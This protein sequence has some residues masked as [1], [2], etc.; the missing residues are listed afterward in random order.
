MVRRR[1]SASLATGI[2]VAAALAG[3]GAPPD[4]FD[5]RIARLRSPEILE[6]DAAEADLAT[7]DAATL[8]RLAEALLAE[9]DPDAR[10]RIEAVFRSLLGPI[11]EQWTSRQVAVARSQVELATI[12]RRAAEGTIPEADQARAQVLRERIRSDSEAIRTTID[13]LRALG[14]AAYPLLFPLS[15]YRPVEARPASAAL[16]QEAIAS[17][18]ADPD[19]GDRFERVRYFL[20]HVWRMAAREGEAAERAARLLSRHLEGTFDDAFG[21]ERSQRIRA[22]AV[23]EL[24]LLDEEAI[25]F[26]RT[27]VPSIEDGVGHDARRLLALL[28]R[29]I[30]ASL[31]E[32]T[33][34][35]LV[36]FEGRS[37]I[38][39]RSA[40]YEME[41]LGREDAIPALRRILRTDPSLSVQFAAA[42]SLARLRDGD[43]IRYLEE[44]GPEELSNLPAVSRQV[45]LIE[46]I[47]LR[48]AGDLEGS[49][50]KLRA[51]LEESPGDFRANYEM[52]FT[53]LLARR[54][55]EAIQHFRRALEVDP[56]DVLSLYNLACAYA[57]AGQAGEAL[58]AL[59]AA[60][61][62]GFE[63]PEHIEAD[64]DLESLRD[65]D[66][67]K[68]IV[69]RA[70]EKGRAPEDR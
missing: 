31:A 39:R 21:P 28:E 19:P 24:F 58:D 27:K 40:V 49:I 52:A 47:R 12:E 34:I 59:E 53:M 38:E 44:K 17:F 48:E 55:P 25:A 29:R 14:P 18:R 16:W 36:G 64:P 41:R 54:F 2:L 63:D 26:L 66:R 32:R 3:A 45:F 56:K 33:G 51:V 69:E 37:W 20:S 22:R 50:R 60:V 11:V 65:R 35:D 43:G 9:P 57:L 23:E 7:F 30:P 10:V 4:P 13:E 42:E 8:P 61:D 68:R 62:N 67:F 15:P 1:S 5:A 46:G 6:R 70:R